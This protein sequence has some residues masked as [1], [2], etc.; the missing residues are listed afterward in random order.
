MAIDWLLPRANI[1]YSDTDCGPGCANP[2]HVARSIQKAHISET[3][4]RPPCVMFADVSSA[5]NTGCFFI[6]AESEAQ[7]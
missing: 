7:P 3:S 4:P 6:P 5:V 2:L 1:T